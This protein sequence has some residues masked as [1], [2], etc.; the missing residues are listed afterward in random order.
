MQPFL[1][2]AETP[3]PSPTPGSGGSFNAD[4]LVQ[5]YLQQAQ[6]AGPSGE[7]TPLAQRQIIPLWA[8]RPKPVSGSTNPIWVR[9]PTRGAGSANA[10][11]NGATF[12]STGP[13]VPQSKVVDSNTAEV[14][15]LDMTDQER[16]SFADQAKA[17]GLWNPTSGG[18][19]LAQAWSHAVDLA[20]NY[21]AS[22]KEGEW[23][24]PFEAANKLAI[25]A[26]ADANA[27]HDAFSTQTTHRS[28]SQTELLGQAKQILQQEL[29]RNP[30]ASEMKVFTSAVNRAS[31]ASP[32]TVTTR[33]HTDASGNTQ[34]DQ[35][36][37]DSGYD[38]SGT[39]LGMVDNTKESQNYQAV[40]YYQAALA[41]LGS[42]V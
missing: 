38:P 30:T 14:Y 39:I 16:M 3:P 29:G 37:Q 5:M 31:A 6:D 8:T 28:Y 11:E 32:T 17:S 12:P 24:S 41:A 9:S 21:N 15:W 25:K 26:M 4:S 23:L 40:Q 2:R 27:S 10:A 34:T 13:V 35:Q 19:G 33:T 7:Q 18:A 42:I 36:V 1:P 20:M 22:H